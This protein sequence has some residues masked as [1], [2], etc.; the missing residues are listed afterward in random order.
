MLAQCHDWHIPQFGGIL[1][2]PWLFQACYLHFKR[3]IIIITIFCK[4]SHRLIGAIKIGREFNY[5][6]F[7]RQIRFSQVLTVLVSPDPVMS[8]DHLGVWKKASGGN[9]SGWPPRR[10]CF[11]VQQQNTHTHT[12]RDNDSFNPP[13]PASPPPKMLVIKITS[14]ATEK[15]EKA[16]NVLLLLWTQANTIYMEVFARRKRLPISPSAI[17]G[18]N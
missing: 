10:N 4:T 13:P 9:F 1:W 5:G 12:K 6:A 2:R 17:I 11:T 18:K 16:T 8:P 14:S 7:Y 3:I 15:R